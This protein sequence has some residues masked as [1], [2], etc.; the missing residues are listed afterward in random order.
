MKRN[1][2]FIWM[3][4]VF[5][6]MALSFVSLDLIFEHESQSHESFVKSHKKMYCYETYSGPPNPVLFVTDEKDID[7]IKEYYEKIE[8]GNLNATFNFPPSFVPANQQVYV[9]SYDRDSSVAKIEFYY[10]V[11]GYLNSAAGY[12]YAHTLHKDSTKMR[13]KKY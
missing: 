1:R 2:I 4:A 8:H 5:L 6:L 13:L 3:G 12:V 7:S 10:L 11:R 9:L